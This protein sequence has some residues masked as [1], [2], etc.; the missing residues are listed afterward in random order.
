VDPA[1]GNERARQLAQHALE[2]SPDLVEARACLVAVFTFSWDWAAAETEAQRALASDPTNAAALRTAGYLSLVLGRWDDAERQIRA[3]LARDPFNRYAIQNLG[4]FYYRTGRY[5]EA[6]VMYRKALELAPGAVWFHNLA[7][8]ALLQQGKAEAAL[9]MVQQEPDEGYRLYF[10]PI[11]LHA[12][13]RKAEADEALQALIAQWADRGAFYIAVNYA[14]LGDHDLA[15][16][17][18]E[19]A[20]QQKDVDFRS[21][22]GEPLLKNLADE[23]R[24]KAL[25]RKM[26]LLE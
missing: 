3:A 19:R 9:A 22:V 16:Q 10:L 7:G 20:Y 25:L 11:M 14:Y 26:K 15:L 2:L 1:E 8:A 17:W 12:N 6:E 23:P 4:E 13:G 24:Y 21:I 5:A 18:L